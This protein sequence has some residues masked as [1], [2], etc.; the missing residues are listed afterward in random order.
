M[1]TLEERLQDE[2][3]PAKPPDKKPG[4]Q[5]SLE[6]ALAADDDALASELN[7]TRAE[8][9]IALR[10]RRIDT[11]IGSRNPREDRGELAREQGVEQS[12]V[13]VA[14]G[15]LDKGLDAN[16]VGRMV[17]YML[18]SR[19]AGAVNLGVPGSPQGITLNDV[20][21]VIDRLNKKDGDSELKE[22][23]GAILQNQEKQKDDTMKALLE[24]NKQI[25]EQIKTGGT[26]PKAKVTIFKADGTKEAL[27]PGDVYMESRT[28]SGVSVDEKREE[29]RHAEEKERIQIERE[30]K[31]NAGETFKEIAASVGEMAAEYVESKG[32]Q[33]AARRQ[34]ASQTETPME[35]FTCEECGT[36]LKIPV[37]TKRFT[38]PKCRTLYGPKKE[39]PPE[40]PAPPQEKQ[41]A[42]AG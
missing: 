19:S 29:N 33:P 32:G 4:Q 11:L 18:G 28:Q 23:L 25:L 16:V 34:G 31:Q 21:A 1:P 20:L 5:S 9:L 17:D 12:L 36:T 24:Q 22:M 27:D 37:G 40:P 10:R 41:N 2:S 26:V 13:D 8:E 7:R 15:L 35:D 30:S 3:G 39:K 38:C 14:Q 42:P 6:K